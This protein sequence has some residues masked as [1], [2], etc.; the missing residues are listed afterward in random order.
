M[1]K[2]VQETA[3]E[4]EWL[5]GELSRLGIEAV[6]A[7]NMIF[8]KSRPRLHAFS[9]MQGIMVRD[10]S[11]LEGL[12]PG[13]YRIAVRSRSDNEKMIEMLDLWCSQPEEAD[14]IVQPSAEP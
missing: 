9:I 5:L 12:E 11:S 13:Y 4:R 10:C 6:G 14:D 2:T 1:Q 7:A 8:F 3:K